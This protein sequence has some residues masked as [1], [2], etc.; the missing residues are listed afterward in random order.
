VI[1]VR[2]RNAFL[3]GAGA[4]LK[5]PAWI[6]GLSLMGI[7]PLARDV[8]FPLIVA[9]LSTV[10]VW[11]GPAQVVFFG[12]LGAGASLAATAL[13]VTLT[14]IRLLPMT[15]SLTPLL[16]QGGASNGRLLLAS[17]F[18]AVTVWVES[19]RRLPDLPLEERQPFFFG[20]GSACIGL[21]T[22][23]TGL[24]YLLAGQVPAA[25]GAGLLFMTPAFFTLSLMGGAKLRAD[26]LA[27]AAGFALTP[28][29]GLWVGPAP[30]LFLAGVVGGTAA[31]LWERR[32]GESRA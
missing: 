14:A 4:A 26:W 27:I 24:G 12:M 21:A 29:F 30:A 9:M 19:M 3:A 23:F 2:P 1:A 15:A 8:G 13:A 5:L 16:R 31:F 11:A 22:L 7:G 10:L 17:H 6:V 25:I 32:A 28:P 18:I 20:F